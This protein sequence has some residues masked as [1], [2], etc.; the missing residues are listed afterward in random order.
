MQG[1]A[2]TPWILGLGFR[3]FGIT[4]AA[5]ATAFNLSGILIIRYGK[6][7]RRQGQGYNQKMINY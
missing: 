7:L 1:Y 6:R 3:N 5:V 4:A 2:V